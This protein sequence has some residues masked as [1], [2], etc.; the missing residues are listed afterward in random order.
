M[1]LEITP[2]AQLKLEQLR[3]EKD[4]YLLLWYDTEGCGCGVS[5]LPAIRFIGERDPKHHVTIENDDVHVLIDEAKSVFFANNMKLDI[6]NDVF[7]LS[8]HEG[9]L[10]PI[11]PAQNLLQKEQD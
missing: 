2:D 6:R 1:K 11:I 7:R 8:S 3:T 10:N 9:I 4:H 5:G